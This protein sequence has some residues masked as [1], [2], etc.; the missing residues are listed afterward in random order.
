MNHTTPSWIARLLAGAE[1]QQSSLELE[2]ALDQAR[3]QAAACAAAEASQADAQATLAQVKARLDAVEAAS[4]R[5]AISVKDPDAPDTPAE[6]LAPG[7]AAAAAAEAD[8]GEE[9][10]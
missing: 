8:E 2:R 4:M 5:A 1:L 3:Q 9:H 7:N 6:M 10:L